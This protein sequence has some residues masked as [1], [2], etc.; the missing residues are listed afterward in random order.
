MALRLIIFFLPVMFV[1]FSCVENLIFI[2]IHP[3]KQTYM[4]FESMGDSLDI[5]N[6]DF[7]HP[8]ESEQWTSSYKKI[9]DTND[10]WSFITEGSFLESKYIFID[11]EKSNLGYRYE[12]NIIPSFFGVQYEFRL[13]FSGTKIKT[14]FPGLY[15][16]IISKKLDS[17]YW[18][19]EALIILMDKGLSD[20]TSDSLSPKKIIWNK[21]LVNHMRNSFAKVD[22]EKNLKIIEKDRVRFLKDL[23]TPF[24]VDEDFPSMLAESMETHEDILRSKIDLNDD[25][26]IIKL[27]MPGQIISTNAINMIDDTLIWEFGIDSL[28][29]QDY[30]LKANSR[31]Y[32]IERLEKILISIGVIVFLFIGYWLKKHRS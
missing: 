22:I 20:L 21:R 4:K 31:L 8:Y 13:I 27:L 1:F 30:V 6:N 10:N 9:N 17:L 15:D 18:I 11:S 32:T 2:Q 26:F 28:L 24:N 12:K 25:N 14:E 19:P 5:Y 3:G 7:I 29:N 16:A 23:L